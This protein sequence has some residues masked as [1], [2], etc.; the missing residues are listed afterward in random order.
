MTFIDPIIKNNQT[1]PYAVSHIC[2]RSLLLI[3]TFGLKCFVLEFDK[4]VPWMSLSTVIGPFL[5]PR[6]FSKEELDILGSPV[7]QRFTIKNLLSENL[8]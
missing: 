4:G 8:C 5:F 3:I 1:S 7:A 2:L 6:I